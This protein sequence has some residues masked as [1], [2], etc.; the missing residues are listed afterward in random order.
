MNSFVTILAISVALCITYIAHIYGM[1]MLYLIVCAK[2]EHKHQFV[3][4]LF[5]MTKKKKE[6]RM[7][8]KV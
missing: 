7:Y 4:L 3:T 1:S 6:R 2:Q 5:V 8:R